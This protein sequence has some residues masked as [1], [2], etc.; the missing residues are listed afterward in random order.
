[1]AKGT[2]TSTMTTTTSRSTHNTDTTYTKD[3]HDDVGPAGYDLPRG[4]ESNKLLYLLNRREWEKATTV[5]KKNPTTVKDAYCTID[6]FYDGRFPSRVSALHL[7]CAL[8]APPSMIQAVYTAHPASVGEVEST[9]GR[10]PLHIAVLNGIPPN[11]LSQLIKLYPQGTKVQD[12]HGRLPIHYAC[13]GRSVFTQTPT[14]SSSSHSM[15]QQQQQASSLPSSS[16]SSSLPISVDVMEKNA[17]LLLR[18][19]PDCVHVPDFQGFLPLHVACRSSHSSLIIR[20][21][22]RSAPDTILQQTLKGSTAIDCAKNGKTTTAGGGRSKVDRHEIVGM[23]E[24]CVEESSG[25]TVLSAT[26]KIKTVTVAGETSCVPV[27]TTP[28]TSPRKEAMG[29]TRQEQHMEADSTRAPRSS[30]NVNGG[31][32]GGWGWKRDNR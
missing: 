19:Y 29:C 17:L 18:A 22:I 24:R 10:L 2:T 11:S 9:Y 26:T 4:S 32:G 30:R 31:G 23:L 28:P 5:V 27:R 3:V 1:M 14:A 12:L 8:K 6:K 7:A 20:T 13:K 16:L 21:L 25:S 15:E